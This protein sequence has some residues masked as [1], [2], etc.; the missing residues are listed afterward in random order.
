M[1]YNTLCPYCGVLMLK[2]ENLPNARSVEHMIPNTVLRHPRNNGD[3]D[4]YACRR[5]NTRKSH[6]DYV[7]GVIAKSQA[8]DDEFAAQVLIDAVLKPD[9]RADR[10]VEMVRSVRETA[11]GA[12]MPLPFSGDELLAYMEFL[13]KGQYFRKTRQMLIPAKQV[14]LF[15]FVN[16]E[17]LLYVKS[18]YETRHQ[19]NPFRDLERNAGS[20]VLAGGDCIIYS[21]NKNYLFVFHDYIGITIRVRPRN[22]KNTER[23]RQSRERILADFALA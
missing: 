18:D 17:I 20:E 10:F 19:S 9:N 12:E 3:G 22:R 14:M 11:T 1:I 16:K 21:K 8:D 5:C 4:F 7:L 6:M 13:A 2:A 15:R 23:E